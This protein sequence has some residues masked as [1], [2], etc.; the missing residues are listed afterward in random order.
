VILTLIREQLRTQRSYIVWAAALIATTV[1]V[2]AFAMGLGA[3]EAA[4]SRYA[5][6]L[7]GG[8][9]DK[10]TSVAVADPATNTLP[11]DMWGTPITW[12]ALQA[13][14]TQA[15]NAG[16]G[17][18][19]VASGWLQLTSDS[20]D[21]GTLG[22]Q[23]LGASTSVVI[24]DFPWDRTLARGEAPAR[25]QVVL[26]SWMAKQ[27]GVDVGDTVGYSLGDQ[28]AG[29][30]VVSGVTY[31]AGGWLPNLR[32]PS[33][34]LSG[35]D[36]Q[37]AVDSAPGPQGL[38]QGEPWMQFQVN[39]DGNFAPL[40]SLSPNTTAGWTGETFYSPS[41]TPWV[42][43][44]MLSGGVAVMAFAAGRARAHERVRWSATARALGAT[45]RTVALASLGEGAAVTVVAGAAGIAAGATAAWVAHTIR[46]AST[47]DAPHI[48]F[49]FPAYAV[50]VS[51]IVAVLLGGVVAA[52]PAFLASRVAPA[53][54]LKDVAAIDEA[55]A[56][57]RVSVWPVVAV[58]AVFYGILLWAVSA[59]PTT[60]FT[61]WTTGVS[62]I[63]LVVTCLA[64]LIE[65]S[66]SLARLFG[67]RLSRS[68]RPWAL[69]AG[70]EMLAHPRQ[71]AALITL[72]TLTAGSMAAWAA[73]NA[74]NGGYYG[75]GASVGLFSGG[76]LTLNYLVNYAVGLLQWRLTLAV[77][78]TA[79][80]IGAATY[81]ATRRLG[82][83]D[84]RV[85]SAL[86]LDGAA[87]L[88]ATAARLALSSFVGTV[89]GA[90]GGAIIA[91]LP[92]MIDRTEGFT[93]NTPGQNGTMVTAL[94]L[95]VLGIV[96]MGAA[97]SA[98][99]A[100]VIV[101]VRVRVRRARRQSAM[102]VA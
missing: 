19:A 52:V 35:E 94:A 54:A 64:I 29:T 13:T 92:L 82:E 84:A 62:T 4:H 76:T 21:R 31:T 12:D 47:L 63:A 9:F 83:D 100:F 57:R 97:L 45:R 88:K 79:H 6:V 27:L 56:S 48:T 24:G 65:G 34:Y 42:L 78:I 40:D 15:H 66:R 51:G 30:L 8:A 70:I 41:T 11:T 102:P 5:V 36:A 58:A 10:E 38:G 67:A 98:L 81:A 37:I 87:A 17:A 85:A 80:L 16:V 23:P 18:D 101:H 60:P 69:R 43:A 90:L 3:T 96:I 89:I 72:H 33:A 68:D 1:A 71:A 50:L 55:E 75:N 44:A 32:T 2:V 93:S 20:G 28:P 46:Q 59:V 49:S 74:G 86:G 53:A 25:G 91:G 26:S 61:S 14:M 39:W 77:L 22:T 73:T 95:G 99:V 7:G